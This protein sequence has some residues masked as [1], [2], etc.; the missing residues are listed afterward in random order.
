MVSTLGAS[1]SRAVVRLPSV[2]PHSVSSSRFLIS[3]CASSLGRHTVLRGPLSISN[4]NFSVI[5]SNA[6]GSGAGT[7]F[8]CVLNSVA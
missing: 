7:H 1:F 4:N 8:V 5:T 2:S 3:T 6:L